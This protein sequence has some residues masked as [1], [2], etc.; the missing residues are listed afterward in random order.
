MSLFNWPEHHLQVAKPSN[1]HETG[2]VPPLSVALGF[3]VRGL[4]KLLL[5]SNRSN[6]VIDCD[7]P[8]AS[9]IAAK[10]PI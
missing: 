1:V 4:L 10:R 6:D 2:D 3:R 7:G 5:L 8:N 9:R